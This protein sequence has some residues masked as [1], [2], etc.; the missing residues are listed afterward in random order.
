MVKYLMFLLKKLNL[1]S[2]YFTCKISL[3]E[4]K[5]RKIT[6]RKV[7]IGLLQSWKWLAKYSIIATI[8]QRSTFSYIYVGH[9]RVKKGKRSR[10][11]D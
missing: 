5:S 2:A 4:Q 1:C 3:L 9:R 10:E 11:N 6:V 7:E 8:L